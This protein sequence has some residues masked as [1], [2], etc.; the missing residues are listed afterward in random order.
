MS[1]VKKADR[2][3]DIQDVI[4]RL[5]VIEDKLNTLISQ[6]GE[7]LAFLRVL[8][9]PILYDALQEVFRTPK[10]L[11]I[12]ELSNGARSTREIGKLVKLDQKGISN[13]WREWEKE[14]IVEKVGKKGQHK[15]RYSLLELLLVYVPTKR[16]KSSKE[17]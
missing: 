7:L 2:D 11:Y 8:A 3:G 13:L 15:A 16:Q 9:E 4:D 6:N 1:P 12:Y 14:G 5:A 10:Q 17:S